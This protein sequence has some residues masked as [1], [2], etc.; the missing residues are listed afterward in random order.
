MKYKAAY[1]RAK[2]IA[3]DRLEDVAWTH[4]E[5]TNRNAALLLMFLLNA[6]K[7]ERFKY[8]A[9]PEVQDQTA[10]AIAERTRQANERIMRLR[11]EAHQRQG[12]DD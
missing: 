3:A 8:K 7:P 9:A 11:R 6:Y 10:P 2:V 12:Q 4:A 1:D 5:S